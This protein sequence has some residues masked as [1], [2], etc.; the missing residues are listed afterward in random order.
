MKFIHL[1]DLHLGKRVNEFNMIDDQE[2]ILKE[3]L[4]IIDEEKP[5]GVLI[6]G[7]I[8]DKAVP[9][10]EAVQLFDDFL[11]SLSQKKLDVF[12][13][14]GNHD[15]P[16]RLAFASR[17]LNKSGIHLSPVYDGNIVCHRM[18]D[19]YGPVNV[20][21]LPFVKPAHV[22]RFYPEP[23]IHTTDEAVKTALK[24][25][26]VD[27]S[28]RN[29][30]LAHQ[31]VAGALPSE[32]EEVSVG[33]TD[34]VDASAFEAFDYTALGH[35]HRPQEIG[36][37]N[38][39]YCGSPLKYSFSEVSNEK[40]VTVV[41]LKEKGNLKISCIPLKPL[42]EMQVLK[43]TYD[44]L[45]S[46]SFYIEKNTDAYTHL[47]LTDENDIPDAIGKLR[48]IYP[49]LMKLSYDN[50]RTKNTAKIEEGL[51]EIRQS[52]IELFAAFYE[53]QNGQ[54]LSEEQ[55][56]FA[57]TLAEEIWGGEA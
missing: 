25:A 38:V 6:A 33:G 36:S 51:A 56:A 49:N 44:E 32:S 41:T 24:A 39:R 48:I 9:S 34:N 54:E 21:L 11:T 31:F 7:D 14:Y 57:K 43:G 17:L 18:E 8:Y 35:L 37:L 26:S 40:S 2:F 5:D 12:I 16:E 29:I 30:L 10:Q 27:P 23:E 20:F 45:A 28:E 3:I 46:R 13:I 15:S 47:T 1:S 50:T 55:T 53:L 4:S 42:H 19:E 22:R 52:P